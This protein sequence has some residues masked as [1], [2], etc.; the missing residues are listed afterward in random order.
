LLLSEAG[1]GSTRICRFVRFEDNVATYLYAPFQ[2]AAGLAPRWRLDATLGYASPTPRAGFAPLY[3]IASVDG[4]QLLDSILVTPPAMHT[5]GVDAIGNWFEDASNAIGNLFQDAA[6][7]LLPDEWLPWV[8]EGRTSGFFVVPKI[9]GPRSVMFT[10]ARFSND[11]VANQAVDLTLIKDDNSETHRNVQLDW[12]TLGAGAYKIHYDEAV[13]QDL[14]WNSHYRVEVRGL[15]G[16]PRCEISTF[17]RGL[18]PPGNVQNAGGVP[19]QPI[20][21]AQPLAPIAPPVGGRVIVP[22]GARLPPG[23]RIQPRADELANSFTVML[24]SCFHY[25]SDNGRVA[26]AYDTIWNEMRPHLKFLVGDQV[27]VDLPVSDYAFRL[28]TEWLW[29]FLLSKYRE[30]WADELLPVLRQGLNCCLSDD[31]EYFNNYPETPAYIPALGVAAYRETWSEAARSLFRNVQTVRPNP[32]FQFSLGDSLSFYVLDTRYNRTRGN[33]LFVAADELDRL[34]AWVNGLQCPGVIASNQILFEAPKEG[35]LAGLTQE[36]A[37]FHYDQYRRLCQILKAAPHDLIF[38]TG[39][40]HYGRIARTVLGPGRTLWEIVSSP[41][42][43]VSSGWAGSADIAESRW[44]IGV[45]DEPA[46]WPQVNVPNVAATPIEYLRA[47]RGQDRD[48]TAEHF[49]TLQ[50]ARTAVV[51]ELSV[52]VAA[53]LPRIQHSNGGPLMDFEYEFRVS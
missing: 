3:V 12:R 34:E 43:L 45:D 4:N 29:Y 37:L 17:P 1:A 40:V 11:N 10:V 8:P 13:V 41:M 16:T 50:F 30:S 5:L 49:M 22:G 18:R 23:L 42:S 27:Y 32:G 47:V 44:R 31:H 14:D 21:A 53:W 6:Q 35:A 38:V 36:R 46:A 51:G 39:D 52:S 25:L 28:S 9:I 2:A 15:D 19:A 20:A 33:N 48:R 24:G 7:G 26:A